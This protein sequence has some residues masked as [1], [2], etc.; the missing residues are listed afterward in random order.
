MEKDLEIPHRRIHIRR[1]NEDTTQV[2]EHQRAAVGLVG[3]PMVCKRM[4]YALGK[5][6][7]MKKPE[8]RTSNEEVHDTGADSD[9]GQATM[10]NRRPMWQGD[11]ERG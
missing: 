4:L 8:R 10:Y 11:V 9:K 1:K 7:C 6:K 5:G 2:P 3:F